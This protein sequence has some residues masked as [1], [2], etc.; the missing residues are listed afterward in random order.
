MSTFVSFHAL[1]ALQTSSHAFF[2]SSSALSPSHRSR[3][4]S[5]KHCC[6]IMGEAWAARSNSVL[7]PCISLVSVVCVSA[8]SPLSWRIQIL[9][10][11]AIFPTI[12]NTDVQNWKA[13]VFVFIQTVQCSGLLVGPSSN[14]CSVC[15]EMRAHSCLK[16]LQQSPC[17]EGNLQ[18]LCKIA[19]GI[20]FRVPVEPANSIYFVFSS[21]DVAFFQNKLV[22]IFKLFY[23]SF[24]QTWEVLK[25]PSIFALS[26]FL[27]GNFFLLS[28]C[29][30]N[31][32]ILPTPP[33]YCFIFSH[34]VKMNLNI[35][36]FSYSN[37]DASS[38]IK[39]AVIQW[40]AVQWHL[41]I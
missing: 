7:L 1:S 20:S 18:Q 25:C 4:S 5:P 40:C 36:T 13:H 34:Y 14:F 10:L 37:Y 9:L 12:W 27:N 35:L 28:A 3:T 29:G 30:P 26:L 32:H 15:R 39:I 8:A 6:R 19:L 22:N 11:T 31:S 21:V 16:Q 38:L 41:I 33:G 2:C 17:A 24:C 23:C